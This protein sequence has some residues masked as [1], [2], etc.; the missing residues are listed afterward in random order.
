MRKGHRGA[1]VVVLL[2]ALAACG[3]DSD[4]ADGAEGA[5]GGDGANEVVLKDIAFKP[6]KLSIEVGDS[7]TW[8]FEDK[9]IAHNVVAEDK[10]FESETK[11]SGTF[12]HT[13]ETAGTFPYVCTVHPG[14]TGTVEAR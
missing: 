12:E 10:S 7:V 3:G 11:D 14:M 9:G 2:V 13:F 1:A 5:V 4:T 8:K 6:E